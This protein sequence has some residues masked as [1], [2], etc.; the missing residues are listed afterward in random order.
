MRSV[1]QGQRVSGIL[2]KRNFSYHILMP[3]DL[4]NYTDL[5]MGTVKQTQAIPFTGPISLL[6]TQLR[7]LAGDV[8]QVEGTE[9]ITIR[10]FKS[11]TLVHEAGMVVLEV[12]HSNA[13][14]HFFTLLTVTLIA[15]PL[16]DMYADAVTT[17]I[18]EVQSNP[19]AQKFHESRKET[20]DMAVRRETGAH[21]AVSLT[22]VEGA[23]VL[24]DMFGR[25]RELQRQ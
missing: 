2:V 17:V 15:N 20:F 13:T 19:T 23:F 16:N 22:S 14:R 3:S 12:G 9:K 11:I 18:L 7:S 24:I 10:I 8:E 4:S 6:V 25:L 21:A 5:S 1:S